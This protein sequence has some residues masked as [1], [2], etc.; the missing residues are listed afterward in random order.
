MQSR[1]DRSQQAQLHLE[2]ASQGLSLVLALAPKPLGGGLE[3]AAGVPETRRAIPEMPTAIPEMPTAISET[4]TAIPETP[5][6]I[7]ETPTAIF[8]GSSR[9]THPCVASDTATVRGVRLPSE[10]LAGGRSAGPCGPAAA[11]L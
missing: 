6:A 9:R 5:T 7:S 4:P 1:P 3:D 8:Y 2:R 10:S 11:P